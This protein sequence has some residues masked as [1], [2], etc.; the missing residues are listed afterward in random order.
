M[1]TAAVGRFDPA[2]VRPDFPI[3]Q[4]RL[5]AGPDTLH[6]PTGT[7]LVYLDNA[8]TTQRPRQVI[9]SL[10]D[11]YEKHYANVHRGIHWLSDQST[12]L[13]EEAREKVRA[14]INAPSKE[15]VI[16]TYGTTEG[17]NLVARS[18]GDANVRAGD[19]I[20]LSEMEHHSNLVPWY[21]LAERTGCVVRHIPITDDG[22]LQLD[23]LPKLLSE[24][25]KLVA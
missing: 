10:V 21:Q 5:H 16:V 25:T 2:T 18:W 12:D 23:A 3:L 22:Q 4:T 6:G 9:Q 14:F 13:Y 8:A 7:P 19:E 1:A 24:K 20:L 17:I 11:V 15:E